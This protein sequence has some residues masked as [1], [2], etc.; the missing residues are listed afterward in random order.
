MTDVFRW[1]KN[2]HFKRENLGRFIRNVSKQ[3]KKLQTAKGG[4]PTFHRDQSVSMLQ[5]RQ[6][7]PFKRNKIRLEALK[8]VPFNTENRRSGN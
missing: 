1:R 8:T 7:E 5:G 4:P 6:T 2:K 3:V